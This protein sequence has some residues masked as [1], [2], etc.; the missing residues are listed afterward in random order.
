MAWTAMPATLR[1][2]VEERLGAPVTRHQRAYGGYGPSVSLRLQA[3]NGARLFV[4]GA[5]PESN[6]VNWRTIPYEQALYE[7]GALAGIAPAYRGSVTHTGWH[8]LLLEDL[9]QG[10]RVPPWTPE[11]ARAVMSDIARFHATVKPPP[12]VLP[13][14]PDV[15]GNWTRVASDPV[16]RSAFMALF[17]PGTGA[18]AWLDGT[19]P[20]LRA[21][22]DD[23]WSAGRLSPEVAGRSVFL[24]ADIRSDNLR[25]RDGRLILFDWAAAAIGPAIFDPVFFLPSLVAES[26]LDPEPLLAHYRAALQSHG[27]AIDERAI[28]AAAALTAGYFAAAAGLPVPPLLPRLRM[29]QKAQLGPALRFATGRLGLPFPE[30]L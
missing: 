8:L 19:L 25:V 2:L 5:G 27:I 23:F 30:L 12:V 21:A 3:E 14:P 6:E 11:R 13:L 17:A 10:G 26:A 20:A 7:S 24:H 4:K 9:G 15:G 16:T 28:D 22:E 1:R 18:A 29:V